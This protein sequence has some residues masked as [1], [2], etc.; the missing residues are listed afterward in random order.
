MST[1]STHPPLD[2]QQLRQLFLLRNLTIIGILTVI[3]I[4]NYGFKIDLP[5][6]ALSTTTF[7]IVIFNI[8]AWLR[9]LRGNKHV[10]HNEFFL[11]LLIDT[12]FFG[13]LIYLSGGA[14]N[15]FGMI[16]LL[17]IIISAT[18]LPMIY[19]WSLAAIAIS[20][21]SFLVWVYKPAH[22]I[23]HNDGD[24]FSLHIMGMWTGFVFGTLI[25]AYFVSRLGKLLHQQQ[26]DLHTAHK[27]AARDEQLV[28]LGTL[29]A[30]TAHELNTPLGTVALISQTLYED[31]ETDDTRQQLHIIRTQIERCKD[32]L[33]NLSA[34][35]GNLSV[36]G[37][38]SMHA[39]E[40]I[41]TLVANWEKRR[42]DATITFQ[43]SGET[44]APVILIDDSLTHALNN[45]L[46]N[47]ADASPDNIELLAQWDQHIINIDIYDSGPGLDG[48]ALDHL[49]KRP[50]SNKQD[51]L[52]LG[53]FIAYAVIKRF[54]GQVSLTNRESG[55]VL[56]HISLP[57]DPDINKYD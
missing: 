42:S 16:F 29:A 26:T 18:V 19:T 51:G 36:E 8:L 4:A 53:L 7:I 15:P 14:S 12:F 40:F 23:M 43:T 45:I 24:S 25:V 27:Q 46:D 34:C 2:S 22:N 44:P 21:Y 47:A 30:S 37:G 41:Q 31:C 57:I 9:I 13:I 10:S 56:T 52:G 20:F 39:D 55:G 54:G 3:S 17:P 28:A 5:V 49:G 11:H 35:A 1:S 6:N 33:S 38:R 32:A 48:E 50:Y